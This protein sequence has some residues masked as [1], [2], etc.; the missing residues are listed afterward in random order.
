MMDE[1]YRSPGDFESPPFE[2]DGS[3]QSA[4]LRSEVSLETIT[5]REL[6]E[7]KFP[8]ITFVV[9]D[10][11]AQGLSVWA[12]RPKAGKSWLALGISAAVAVGGRA[13]GRIKVEAGDVLYLAL[14]D[15][16][17][18]L[19]RRLHQLL[20][21]ADKPA[22][23]HL[24]TSCPRL[25][26]GGLAAIERWCRS[27]PN[28][29]LVVVDVFNKVRTQRGSSESLYDAD[30]RSVV[31][32]KAL[33]D[34]LDLAVVI[35]HHTNKREDVSDPFDAV[36]GTTGLTGAADTV[37][38][39]ARDGMGT[40]LYGRGRDIA[41]IEVALQFDQQTGQWL[42]LGDAST[43]R[44]T[45]ERKTILDTL[46]SADEPLGPTAIA[47]AAD[48]KPGNVRRLIGKMLKADEIV[49]TGRGKY[50]HPSRSELD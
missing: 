3:D 42:L 43:V 46:Q 7:Q 37:L 18:R 38:I 50:R 15:N 35:I 10:F 40:T 22:R 13:L 12:G 2:S 19:Q 20:P 24:A 36:S 45:D 48:M 33:A 17:R 30:Y 28:P 32:L 44:R 11:V 27:V 47:D 21:N 49:K 8:P 23:L 29:R 5:A 14:E 31:P 34:D 25:D 39:L 16:P 9:P 6:A 26:N 1:N 41:E 4:D